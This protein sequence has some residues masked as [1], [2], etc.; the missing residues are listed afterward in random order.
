MI[1]DDFV[2]DITSEEGTDIDISASLNYKKHILHLL[3]TINL[4]RVH[5][6]VDKCIDEMLY[7][8]DMSIFLY[9]P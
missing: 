6:V 8:I 2:Y 4:I 7:D 9:A 3:I 1:Q 5:S